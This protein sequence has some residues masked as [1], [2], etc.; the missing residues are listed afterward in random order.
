[1]WNL[2]LD[3]YRLGNGMGL[4]HTW[5]TLW[6]SL[7]DAAANHLS[8]PHLRRSLL[9]FNYLTY[10]NFVLFSLL[11]LISSRRTHKLTWLAFNTLYLLTH[12]IILPCPL[13]SAFES[14]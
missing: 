5:N 2:R 7:D 12:L 13:T 3:Y 14:N 10:H 11:Y 9:T 8:T 6:V 4:E 1:M